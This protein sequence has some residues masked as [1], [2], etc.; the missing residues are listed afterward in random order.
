MFD[1]KNNK[2]RKDKRF[3]VIGEESASFIGL[4]TIQD[5]ETGVNYIIVQGVNGTAITPLFDREGKP[6]VTTV[7]QDV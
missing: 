5:K 6:L 4:T 2:N 7:E 3:N 1:N